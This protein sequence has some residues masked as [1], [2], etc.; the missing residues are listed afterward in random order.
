MNPIIYWPIRSDFNLTRR[1]MQFFHTQQQLQQ[2]Q[3]LQVFGCAL[4]CYCESGVRVGTGLEWDC[5]NKCC[6]VELLRERERERD[7]LF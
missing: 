6:F 2:L 7:D 4:G 1:W 3:Q 5:V